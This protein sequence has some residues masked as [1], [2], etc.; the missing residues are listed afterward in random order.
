MASPIM[1]DIGTV[2]IDGDHFLIIMR[3]VPSLK[4]QRASL[5]GKTIGALSCITAIRGA[6]VL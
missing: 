1:L 2:V 4:P 6:Q 5:R 3:L